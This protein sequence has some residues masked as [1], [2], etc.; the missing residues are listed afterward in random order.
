MY[1]DFITTPDGKDKQQTNTRK[2]KRGSINLTS[3]EG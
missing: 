2:Q 3:L 1:W